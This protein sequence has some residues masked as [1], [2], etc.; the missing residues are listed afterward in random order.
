[1]TLAAITPRILGP[2]GRPIRSARPPV[3]TVRARYDAAEVNDENRKLWAPADG[4]SAR[5]AN[6]PD[7]RARLRNRARYEAANNGYASGMAATLAND[8]IGTGPRLQVLADDDDANRIVADAFEGWT[9]AVGLAEK[10]RTMRRSRVVDG[11]SFALLTHNPR[12]PT[13]VQLDLDLV[14]ADQV[15]TP[16]LWIFDAQ[17]V[18]GI[19]YDRYKNPIEYHVLKEHPGE[20]LRITTGDE[21]ERV[22]ADLVLHWFRADRPGQARGVPDITPA[23]P[24]Y[25]L[26]RRYT[27]AVLAAA[28]TAADFAAVLYSDLPADAEGL[29]GEPFETLEITRRMMTTLPAGW[30]MG[31]FQ[32]DQ[33]TTTYQMFKREILSEIARCLNMPYNVAAGD[34]SGYN[35]SSGRLDHQTYYKSISVDQYHLETAILD[36]VLSAWLREARLL[37]DAGQ[38]DPALSAALDRI[39]GPLPH[40]WH[41]DGR[42]HVDPTKEAAAQETRLSSHT[43]TL[44]D[45]W[46]RQ[47]HDWRA[48]LRQRADEL[49]LMRELG[50][51]PA[52]A[53]PDTRSGGVDNDSD[54]ETNADE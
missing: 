19:R 16:D 20:S 10:L 39:A 21:Y 43:T 29:E 54:D 15:A 25:A 3:R 17:A 4:L 44:A 48:K 1:M 37:S 51:T 11:E 7:V 52:Q 31:Q 13:P 36:R 2:S 8:T 53:A 33:P 30:K 23:L 27:L 14:E 35:Y 34:S 32:S 47:G 45:E 24:L 12:L 26:L 38:L 6:S 46:A 22:P 41:W 42:E 9:A 28:E 40:L 18:D 50:I 49:R 5:A